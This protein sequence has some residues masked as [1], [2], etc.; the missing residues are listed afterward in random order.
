MPL[1]IDTLI[2]QALALSFISTIIL[3]GFLYLIDRKKSGFF[4]ANASVGISFSWFCA[5]ILGTPD[6]PPE[7]NSSGILS[8]TVCLLAIGAILDFN[9]VKERK[10]PVPILVIFI[11]G[12]GIACWFRGG[13]DFW[14]LP[15]LLGW[16]V[17]AGGLQ[18]VATNK[19]FGAS[20]SIFLLI[21]ASA[22]SGA[23]AWISGIAVDRDLSFGLFAILTGFY[24]CTW[25]K[26]R[27]NFGYGILLAGGGSLYMIA[28]R[29]IEQMPPL[30]PAFIILGFAFYTDYACQYVHKNIKLIWSIPTS[31][32]L[33]VLTLFPLSLAI[34]VTLIAI[35]FPI[36]QE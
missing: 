2:I 17:I 31:I 35:E 15:I 33:A 23:I 5:F 19:E 13:I 26:S 30:I 1:L 34:V 3:T 32:K 4:M 11:S 21:I 6:F 22:G 36:N 14:F 20:I 12:I 28:I 24:V 18:R 7:F 27:L 25:P 10:F 8:A 16:C 29:L 9:F